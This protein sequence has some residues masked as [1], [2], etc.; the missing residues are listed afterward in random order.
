MLC[1][2]LGFVVELRGGQGSGVAL[3]RRTDLVCVTVSAGMPTIECF[4]WWI[5]DFIGGVLQLR[6]GIGGT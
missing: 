4:V 5:V 6:T 2:C 3:L 1:I